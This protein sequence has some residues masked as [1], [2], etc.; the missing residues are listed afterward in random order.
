MSADDMTH[1]HRQSGIAFP[2]PATKVRYIKLGVGN[3][4]FADCKLHDRME[5]GHKAVPHDV[6][7]LR[8]KDAIAAIYRSQGRTAGKATGYLREQ[9]VLE[10][11]HWVQPNSTL[12]YR[13]ENLEGIA[14]V[15]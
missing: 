12:V 15:G 13:L 1:S 7:R 14:D 11:V 9:Q 3:A 5:F 2:I 8:D 4:W 10:E 6:A